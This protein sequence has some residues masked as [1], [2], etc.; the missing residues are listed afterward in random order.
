MREVTHMLEGILEIFAPLCPFLY[1]ST[2]EVEKSSMG[3]S[4]NSMKK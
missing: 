3:F 2:F 1:S 4:N